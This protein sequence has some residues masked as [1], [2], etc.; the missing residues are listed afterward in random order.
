MKIS[1]DQEYY[2]QVKTECP[3]RTGEVPPDHAR[4]TLL[5]DDDSLG[6]PVP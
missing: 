1:M 4:T 5:E 3:F 2:G 6:T